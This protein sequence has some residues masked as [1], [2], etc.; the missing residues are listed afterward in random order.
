MS[1]LAPGPQPRSEQGVPV[2]VDARGQ[3]VGS[4][5]S[6]CN[7]AGV[8]GWLGALGA[9]SILLTT[10]PHFPR[11]QKARVCSTP[12]KRLQSVPTQLSHSTNT[13]HTSRE[14]RRVR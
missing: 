4:L 13:P 11:P 2:E 12:R 10:H 7:G 3:E 14:Q 6:K 5:R 9:C 1:C 8:L